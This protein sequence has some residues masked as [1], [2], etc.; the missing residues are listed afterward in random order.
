MGGRFQC[1]NIKVLQCCHTSYNFKYFLQNLNKTTFRFMASDVSKNS[2][3]VLRLM[4]KWSFCIVKHQQVK[5]M[6]TF[7]IST[8]TQQQGRRT[9]VPKLIYTYTNLCILNS[10]VRHMISCSIETWCINF[11]TT[12]RSWS[13]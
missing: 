6:M 12:I 13:R 1:H 7:L 3:R 9:G 4:N 5:E 11:S 8:T 10:W 2:L